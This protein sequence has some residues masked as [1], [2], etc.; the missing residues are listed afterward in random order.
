MIQMENK[1]SLGLL[2]TFFFPFVGLQLL[3]NTN[4]AIPSWSHG[5]PA[6]GKLPMNFLAKYSA[7]KVKCRK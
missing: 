2:S 3:T 1:S 4:L 6:H 5:L 7:T